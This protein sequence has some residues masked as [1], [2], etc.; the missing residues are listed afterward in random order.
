[1]LHSCLSPSQ[2]PKFKP[3]CT[4]G[5]LRFFR[6]PPLMRKKFSFFLLIW[7]WIHPSVSNHRLFVASYHAH[8]P[9]ENMLTKKE[10]SRQDRY[11]LF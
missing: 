1:M 5:E 11:V 4:S 6:S 2:V 9:Q 7:S 10:A 8:K 3:G